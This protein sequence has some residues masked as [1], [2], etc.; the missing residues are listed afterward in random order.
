MK[1]WKWQMQMCWY[2]EGNSFDL[3]DTL[4]EIKL[5]EL[6][7]VYHFIF[8]TAFYHNLEHFIPYSTVNIY[9]I[10]KFLLLFKKKCHDEHP[11]IYLL[12]H[13]YFLRITPQEVEFEGQTYFFRMFMHVA[14]FPSKEI[15][16]FAFLSVACIRA[17]VLTLTLI[18]TG[19]RVSPVL[20][21]VFRKSK[22]VW[23][24][25]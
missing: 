17:F 14:N 24:R 19:Y 7:L 10:S 1:E 9:T 6:L 4:E 20:R 5:W 16:Q 12:L 22:C 8:N 21:V 13:I 2:Y 11:Q 18:T 15:Y 3:E 25:C 23:A